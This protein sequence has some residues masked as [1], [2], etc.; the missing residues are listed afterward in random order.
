MITSLLFATALAG[1]LVCPVMGSPVKAEAKPITVAGH[2]FRMCC[3]GCDT[4]FKEKPTQ[5]LTAAAKK[6]STIGE[7]LFDPVTQKRIYDD[8]RAGG[9][10]DYKGVRYYFASA[11]N[12]AAFKAAPQKYTVVPKNEVMH[13]LVM[14]MKIRKYQVADSYSDS[15]DTRY[16]HCCT[17]CK[18]KF[19]KSPATY[20]GK[21][22]SHKK[23][24]QLYVKKAS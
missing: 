19:D 16:Y 1:D 24:S 11:A 23:A 9:S 22:G 5:Y 15:G 21:A 20:T 3:A 4:K 8:E 10:M 17:E 13:C 12:K 6:G 2:E 7:F 18:V 14:D